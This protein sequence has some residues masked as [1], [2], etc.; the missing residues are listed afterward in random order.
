MCLW[1]SRQARIHTNT[2]EQTTNIYLECST[3]VSARVKQRSKVETKRFTGLQM[4]TE[5]NVTL[6][7]E[8]YVGREKAGN[9]IWGQMLPLASLH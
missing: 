1:V 2:Q 3:G 4:L 9:S 6:V 8:D 7:R 5:I